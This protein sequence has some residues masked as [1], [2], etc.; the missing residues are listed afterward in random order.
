MVSGSLAKGLY[1][2]VGPTLPPH[3][4]LLLLHDTICKRT[5]GNE[6]GFVLIGWV[7]LNLVIARESV[8]EGESLVADAIIDNLID[9]RHWEVV[10]GT[11]VIE[12]AKVGAN[13]DRSLFFV[14]GYRVGNP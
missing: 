2:A 12:I 3:L 5:R 10:L 7:D 1:I 8:H 6:C 9:E 13:A 14:D 4:Y 11:C